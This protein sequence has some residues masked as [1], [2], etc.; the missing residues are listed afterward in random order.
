MS[1]ISG[2]GPDVVLVHGV[3]VGPESFTRTA[4]ALA[5]V[6]RRV[7]LAV[8]PGY[9]D[10]ADVGDRAVGL[11]RQVDMVISELEERKE[12]SIVWVGVSGGATL[13]VIAASRRPAAID[14]AVLHE[15]LVGSTAA[16]LHATV[17]MAARQLVTGPPRARRESDPCR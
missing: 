16:A 12:Q 15:P 14:C 11:D 5:D 10:A 17:R 8:R 7:H 1:T 4:A 6:G 2:T 13:G 3:G 9:G